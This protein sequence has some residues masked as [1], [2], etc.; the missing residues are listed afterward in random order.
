MKCRKCGHINPESAV[1]CEKCRIN[2]AWAEENLMSEEEKQQERDEFIKEQQRLVQERPNL[3]LWEY[4]TVIIFP[5]QVEVTRKSWFTGRET[6]IVGW[7]EVEKL[8]SELGIWGWELVSILPKT[9]SLKFKR[10]GIMGTAI[11]ETVT[12]G[13]TTTDYFVAV[14][15]R[16]LPSLST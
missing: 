15:K 10:P 14:F 9:G 1:N 5:E 6:M 12:G 16:P 8:F 2:L 7:D 13:L 4:T 11:G 3:T